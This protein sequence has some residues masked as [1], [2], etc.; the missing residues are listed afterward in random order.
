MI[1]NSRAYNV[2]KDQ[3]T[4]DALF[5]QQMGNTQPTAL[6]NVRQDYKLKVGANV[7]VCNEAMRTRGGNFT[8]CEGQFAQGYANYT[9]YHLNDFLLAP[10][11]TN[12][13]RNHIAC[14]D[15]KC[16]EIKHQLYDNWTKRK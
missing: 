6:R 11:Q 9:K 10:C 8:G 12:T 4:N 7:Y 5:L 1:C 16:C 15:D 3:R 14:D 13:W 2:Y